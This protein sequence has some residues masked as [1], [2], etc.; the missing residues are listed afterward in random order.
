L[1]KEKSIVIDFRERPCEPTDEDFESEEPKFGKL[2]A[3]KQTEAYLSEDLFF[4]NHFY[5][6]RE[7]YLR[8][9]RK[10][11]FSLKQTS[12]WAIDQ[13]EVCTR[14]YIYEDVILKEA[15]LT[16]SGMEFIISFIP[17][18]GSNKQEIIQWDK[19]S[20]LMTGSLLIITNYD[21]SPMVYGTVHF[22]PLL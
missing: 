5:I 1:L 21:L 14:L 12:F 20:R 17:F 11:I 3:L 8:E 2:I 6:L 15:S 19:S 10:G 16:L 13:H 22:K 7:D 4:N 18:Q 9:L